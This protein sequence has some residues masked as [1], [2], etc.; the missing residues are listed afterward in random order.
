MKLRTLKRFEEHDL[1]LCEI[2]LGIL[3]KVPQIDEFIGK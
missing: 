1:E 2:K 3:A